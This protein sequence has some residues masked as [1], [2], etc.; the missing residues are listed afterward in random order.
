[1]L[2]G[3]VGMYRVGIVHRDKER[4][5]EDPL[6][7]FEIGEEPFQDILEKGALSS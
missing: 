2:G 7:V 5:C 1:M 6:S 3:K 4:T